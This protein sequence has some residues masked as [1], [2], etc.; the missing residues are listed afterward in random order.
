M[1]QA[2]EDYRSWRFGRLAQPDEKFNYDVAR[3]TRESTP[4]DR[5]NPRCKT[6]GGERGECRNGVR[7]L[8]ELDKRKPGSCACDH[9]RARRR[10]A[11]NPFA[12]CRRQ[13]RRRRQRQANDREVYKKRVCVATGDVTAI[14]NNGMR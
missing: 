5:D 14:E 2:I 12:Q 11:S 6:H 10:E 3:D 8:A 9:A 7:M 1:Y 4:R 13:R